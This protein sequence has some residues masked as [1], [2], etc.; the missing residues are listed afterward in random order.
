M[1]LI[2]VSY[3]KIE[4]LKNLTDIQLIDFKPKGLWYSPGKTWVNWAYE[5][6][7]I[8]K[9]GLYYYI[10]VP[11]YTTLD[12]PDINKVLAIRNDENFDKFTFKYGKTWEKNS[13]Q[14][15]GL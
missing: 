10:I 1:I 12:K 11:Y 5:N 3:K 8:P 15:H 14:M 9:K 13:S 7:G 6:I 4:E 2:H